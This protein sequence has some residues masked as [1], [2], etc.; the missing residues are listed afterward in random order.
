MLKKYVCSKHKGLRMSGGI[1]FQSGFFET[2]DPDQQKRIE[3][4]REF[5]VGRISETDY[6]DRALVGFPEW[7]KAEKAE[8]L[9]K[10][11]PIGAVGETM[12][13]RI[14]SI[15]SMEQMRAHQAMMKKQK[16]EAEAA[17]E[18]EPAVESLPDGLLSDVDMAFEEDYEF[19]PEPPKLNAT[20]INMLKKSECQRLAVQLGIDPI[21]TATKLKREIKFVLGV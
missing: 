15:E 11:E 5:K 19:D 20:E 4:C 2:E 13:E 16:A 14:S 18:P 12:E 3:N 21:Q 8:A 6:D 9:S 7:Q 10:G 1:K 17:P